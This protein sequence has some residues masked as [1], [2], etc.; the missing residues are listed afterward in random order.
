MH[1]A[2]KNLSQIDKLV[3]VAAVACK[4]N[5]ASQKIPNRD[6]NA[7]AD[8]MIVSK[9]RISDIWHE[10]QR[11]ISENVE[12]EEIVKPKKKARHDFY[13]QYDQET[14]IAIDSAILEYEGLIT[15]RKLQMELEKSN[16][17]VA[18]SQVHSYC[19]QMKVI[20]IK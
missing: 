19:Q 8:D 1:A 16:I 5:H 9:R 17:F 15:Y 11:D 20:W 7:I 2:K 3:A 18:L 14:M 6:L 12:H 13:S 10:Y 4:L